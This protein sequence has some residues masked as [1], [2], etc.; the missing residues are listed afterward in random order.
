VKVF[1]YF[2]EMGMHYTILELVEGKELF[3][4]ISVMGSMTEK[5]ASSLFK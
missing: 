4:E 5:K 3:E 2:Y 1:D